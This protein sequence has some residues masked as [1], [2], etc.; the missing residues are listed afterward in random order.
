MATQTSSRGIAPRIA[1]MDRRQVIHELMHFKG[2]IRLDFTEKFLS[3]K[4]V[5]WLRHVLLA[6]CLEAK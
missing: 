2:R 4:S 1:G 5:D 3:G 6:A